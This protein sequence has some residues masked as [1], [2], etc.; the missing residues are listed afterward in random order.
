M[1]VYGCIW[2]IFSYVPQILLIL[3]STALRLRWWQAAVSRRVTMKPHS[4]L[5]DD[6]KGGGEV[7]ESWFQWFIIYYM[8][9]HIYIYIYTQV[10]HIYIY[11]LIISFF[12]NRFLHSDTG[13]DTMIIPWYWWCHDNTMILVP[14]FIWFIVCTCLHRLVSSDRIQYS[15]E[16]HRGQPS[17]AAIQ[18]ECG[19]TKCRILPPN[20]HPISSRSWGSTKSVTASAG[21]A[22]VGFTYG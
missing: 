17:G 2:H 18:V 12:D 20:C 11:I 19:S 5:D 1:D 16:I 9:I 14:F 6:F 22:A 8:V 10:I 15:P 21:G 3:V 13:S 4:G 7:V